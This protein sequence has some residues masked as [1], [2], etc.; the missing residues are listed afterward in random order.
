MNKEEKVKSRKFFYIALAVVIVAAIVVSTADAMP[1]YPGMLEQRGLKG[2]PQFQSSIRT[3]PQPAPV[4]GS[5]D[6]RGF[7]EP[8]SFGS[9]SPNST[10]NILCVLIE[11][12]DK[13]AQVTGVFFDSLHI[14]VLADPQGPEMFIDLDLR[15]D[16]N[17]TTTIMRFRIYIYRF[18]LLVF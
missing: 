3:C 2:D 12:S 11:F 9:Q 16:R 5:S 17:I 8:L 10:G 18:I 14:G 1:P 13:P 4:P 6:G 15:P 7:G